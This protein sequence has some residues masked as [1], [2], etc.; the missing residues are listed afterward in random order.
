MKDLVTER[1]YN[2]FLHIHEGFSVKIKFYEF[3]FVY[4]LIKNLK[5]NKKNVKR[6]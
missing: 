1:N 3:K 4:F 5:S 6:I 2:L